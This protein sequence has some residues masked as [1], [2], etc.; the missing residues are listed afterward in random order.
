MYKEQ[1]GFL[2][3]FFKKYEIFLKKL[4]NKLESYQKTIDRIKIMLQSNKKGKYFQ[5]LYIHFRV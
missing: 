2:A 4:F 5:S 1:N 3:A